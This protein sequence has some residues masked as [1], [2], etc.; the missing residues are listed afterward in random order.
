M[1]AQDILSEARE[2]RRRAQ[3]Q[4][5]DL[6]AANLFVHTALMRS[7]GVT[8]GLEQAQN[9]V[10]PTAGSEPMVQGQASV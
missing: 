1:Q 9:V 4:G 3:A 5:L 10:P 8:L 6:N 7:L 2:L